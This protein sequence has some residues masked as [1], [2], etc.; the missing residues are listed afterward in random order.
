MCSQSRARCFGGGISEAQ[1]ADSP[2]AFHQDRQE[3]RVLQVSLQ[4]LIFFEN[5][6]VNSMFTDIRSA[7]T[8]PSTAV[9]VRERP[10]TMP[11]SA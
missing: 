4:S 6:A 1:I 10:T 7:A 5:Y 2:V 8:R 11:V 3:Q 9:V